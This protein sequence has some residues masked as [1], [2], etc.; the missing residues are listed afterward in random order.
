[1]KHLAKRDNAVQAQQAKH[2]PDI[3]PGDRFIDDDGYVYL[4][5]KVQATKDGEGCIT[6][7]CAYV[8]TDPVTRTTDFDHFLSG[9]FLK[10]VGT[11]TPEEIIKNKR[12]FTAKFLKEEL[13]A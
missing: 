3:Y 4:V 7:G 8:L 6:Y 10:V 13:K 1:M 9:K 12:S 2:A 5:K 11:G